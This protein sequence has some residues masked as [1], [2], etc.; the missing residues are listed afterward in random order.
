MGA[1]TLV[2]AEIWTIAQTEQ[3]HVILVRPKRSEVAVPIFVG[4]LEAQSILIGLGRVDMPRPLTHD[5]TLAIM[6]GL[7]AE[8]LRIEIYDLRDGTYYARLICAGPAGELSFDARPSDAMALAVRCGAAVYIAES[9]VEEAGVPTDAIREASQLS[10]VEGAAADVLNAEGMGEALAPG[11]SPIDDER[12]ALLAKL[13]EAVASEDY[14]EAARIRD[15][16]N[17]LGT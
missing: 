2:E 15:R 6:G 5:L 10:P 7:G 13:A 12:R 1:N 4:T 8:L 14:E 11:A 9:V 17:G 16:L 3:G